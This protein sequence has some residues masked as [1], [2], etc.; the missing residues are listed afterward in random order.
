MTFEVDLLSL[1]PLFLLLQLV[2]SM[3]LFIHLSI[4]KVFIGHLLLSKHRA[5]NNH[6]IRHISITLFH[7]SHLNNPV[8]LVLSLSPFHR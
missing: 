1:L 4:Q 7:L 2:H 5:K 3:H 6:N 8:S